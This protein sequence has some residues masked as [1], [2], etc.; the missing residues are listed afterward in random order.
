MLYF[1]NEAQCERLEPRHVVCQ[2]YR[3]SFDYAKSLFWRSSAEESK[4]SYRLL[5]IT[6]KMN[7]LYLKTDRQPILYLYEPTEYNEKIPS[8]INKV[9]SLIN[10]RGS[11]KMVLSL[12]NSRDR[13]MLLYY[14]WGFPSFF[15]F[16]AELN[17]RKKAEF[18]A[19]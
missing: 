9:E 15:L 8:G 2:Q 19:Q 5:G 11:N 4:I 7:K 14:L 12:A 13:K 1:K 6:R 10:G 18:N 16:V 3:T 17:F